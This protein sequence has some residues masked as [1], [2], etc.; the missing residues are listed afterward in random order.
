V[1]GTFFV[2]GLAQVNK[3]GGPAYW[4]P[5]GAALAL[6]GC[7]WAILGLVLAACLDVRGTGSR[8]EDGEDVQQGPG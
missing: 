5:I 2:L 4:D 8:R 3:F 6:I 7:A 1:A